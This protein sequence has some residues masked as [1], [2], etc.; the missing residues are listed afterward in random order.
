MPY[1]C[2]ARI[3]LNKA[4]RARTLPVPGRGRPLPHTSGPPRDNCP[5][6]QTV[7]PAPTAPPDAPVG[8]LW[9]TTCALHQHLCSRQRPRRVPWPAAPAPPHFPASLPCGSTLLLSPDRRPPQNR[10][11]T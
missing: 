6:L 4:C 9:H 10:V 5:G 11:H 3:Y 1:L 8:L 2:L 7:S